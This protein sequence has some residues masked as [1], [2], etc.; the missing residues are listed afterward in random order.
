MS[1]TVHGDTLT[2]TATVG[3]TVGATA[4]TVGATGKVSGAK[5]TGKD[6]GPLTALHL[7]ALT[8]AD[9]GKPITFGESMTGKVWASRDGV[10][11]VHVTWRYRIGGKLREIRIGTWCDKGGMTLKALRDERDRMATELR[12]GIDPIERRAA[13]RLKVEA[14]QAEAIREQ[15]QRIEAAQAAQLAEQRRATVRQVFDDWRAA[16][17]QPRVR[18][19]GKR[20]GRVDGG[21]YVFEQFTRHVFPAIGDTA[22]EAVRKAD[23]LALLDAQKSAGKMRT[24]NMLLADLKQML[25]FALEREVI[26]RNPLATVKKSK[27]GGPSVERDRVLAD[28]EIGLLTAAIAD[29]RMNVRSATAIWLTLATGVRVGELMGAVWADAL[30]VD[31]KARTARLSALQRVADAEGVK[32]GIVDAAARTWHLPTTK[33]QRSHTVHL[34]DFALQQMQVLNEHREVLRDSTSGQLTP[35]LFPATDSRKPVCVKSFGKQLADRQREPAQRL[36]NRTKATMA[37]MLPGGRWTAH[38]LRRTAATT[39]AHCGFGSDTI[40]ECLNHIQAD[41]MARV[42]IRDRREADQVRAFDALGQRLV[43]LTTGAVASNVVPLRV[44]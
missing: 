43:E 26:D 18:A 24:A 23:L 12:S 36:S 15:R 13:D 29:A 42:Y 28:D 30:P 9:V 14:D 3:A 5:V 31:P 6:S 1:A 19:D 2:A 7:K 39:M 8:T 41:K 20:T 34:S 44:A 11:S 27:V 10:V 4:K 38:D 33:N 22:L 16:D 40:N 32:L 35:W 21:Q 17:L 37:L 25:D